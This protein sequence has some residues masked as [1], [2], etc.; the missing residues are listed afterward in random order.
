MAGAI[1]EL[2]CATKT[3]FWLHGKCAPNS[4][5]DKARGKGFWAIFLD[6]LRTIYTVNGKLDSPPMQYPVLE[7]IPTH[8]EAG[9]GTDTLETAKREL[10]SVLGSET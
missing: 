5:R 1:L 4:G 6:E 10:K 9:H 3:E 7:A 2:L 8:N